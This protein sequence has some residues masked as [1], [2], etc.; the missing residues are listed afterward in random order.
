[1]KIQQQKGVVPEYYV[2]VERDVQ[3]RCLERDVGARCKVAGGVNSSLGAIYHTF[4][5]G[6]D[7]FSRFCT[8]EASQRS[9]FIQQHGTDSLV[10]L[11]FIA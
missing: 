9:L 7:L 10:I 3:L 8:I 2:V 1:M 11:C 6:S 4:L 5:I